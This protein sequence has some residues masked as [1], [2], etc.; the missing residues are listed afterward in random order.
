MMEIEISAQVEVDKNEQ[1]KE[2]S[3][4]RSGYRSRRLDTRMGTV[5]LMVPKVRKGGYVPF[6]VTEYK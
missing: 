5:Y 3:S 2:R 6:F 1:S 4:Y